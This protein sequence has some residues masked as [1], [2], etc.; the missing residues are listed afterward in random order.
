MSKAYRNRRTRTEYTKSTNVPVLPLSIGG[1]LLVL[2]VTVGCRPTPQKPFFSTWK[3]FELRQ[4][5]RGDY[6]KAGTAI[7]KTVARR[8][9]VESWN[10]KIGYIQSEWIYD[11]APYMALSRTRLVILLEPS[12]VTFKM[13]GELQRRNKDDEGGYGSWFPD[14]DGLLHSRTYYDLVNEVGRTVLNEY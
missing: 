5:L 14:T 10:A 7:V 6:N 12:A 9:G 4:D 13:R 8:Y 11:A 3:V 2:A 1:L